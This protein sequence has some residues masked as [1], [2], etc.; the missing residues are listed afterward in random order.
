MFDT[1]YNI[2]TFNIQQLAGGLSL[3]IS[4]AA[5]VDPCQSPSHCQCTVVGDGPLI[6]HSLRGD[7]S[8]CSS[9]SCP[10]DNLSRAVV[11]DAGQIE[12]YNTSLVISRELE[13]TTNL[14]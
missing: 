4:N 1:T 10:S 5:L 8:C 11:G 7:S 9:I 14:G 6:H 2:Y 12:L 13:G 3:V